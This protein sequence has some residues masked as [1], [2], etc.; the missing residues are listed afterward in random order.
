MQSHERAI[1]LYAGCMESLVVHQLSGEKGMIMCPLA[2]LFTFK[3]NSKSLS[4]SSV[5]P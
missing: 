2:G 5:V 3:L 4:Y 1:A